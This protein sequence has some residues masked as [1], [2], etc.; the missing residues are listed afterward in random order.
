MKTADVPDWL[1]A[2]V[3]THQEQATLKGVNLSVDV[4]QLKLTQQGMDNIPA[5]FDPV[6]MA[7]A[8]DNLV[9]N[10]IRHAPPGS[11]VA[12][13][14]HR[15]GTGTDRRFHLA[16]VDNGLGVP[17]ADRERIFEPFVTGPSDGSGLGLA[18]AREV[19]AAHGDRAYV[20]AP[21]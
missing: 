6:Q 18:V 2:T 9:L 15:A 12:V 3:A 21:C 7:R 4:S 5:K 10:A 17:V 1:A 20:A 19:A 8:L 11:E 13:R 14:A 16:A